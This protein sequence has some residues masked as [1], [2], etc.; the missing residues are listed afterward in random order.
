MLTTS[1][2]FW[3]ALVR[4]SATGWWLAGAVAP[5]VP[6]I[7]RAAA[8]QLAGCPPEA[9]LARTYHRSPWREIH[10]AAHSVW[11]PLLTLALRRQGARQLST[12]WLAHLAV[13]GLT[14]HDDAWPLAWPLSRRVWRSPV[15]YWQG[16]HHARWLL[17][18]DLVGVLCA[19]R[20]V[21]PSLLA[22]FAAAT[23]ARALWTSVIYHARPL[24]LVA[25]PHA[26]ARD[27]AGRRRVPRQMAR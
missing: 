22:L 27:L 10:F 24:G 16:E 6:A 11:T 7:A 5:D 20:R 21:R 9:V 13:D 3:S 12:A 15:S 23:T 8:L 2:L 26:R 19:R 17:T 4:P 14:H 25:D 18:A 1:H